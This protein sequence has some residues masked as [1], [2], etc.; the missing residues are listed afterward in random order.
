MN[1]RFKPISRYLT[2]FTSLVHTPLHPQWLVLRDRRTCQATVTRFARGTVLDIGC[3]NR[4]AETA[5]G[6]GARYIGLDYPATVRL[7]YKGPPDVFGDAQ[8]LPFRDGSIDTV[9][10]LDVLEH[11][12]D[13]ESALCEAARVLKPYGALILQ[14]PF[15]YPLHD[16]P[17]D[18]QRW[19]LYGLLDKVQGHGFEIVSYQHQGRPVETAA[20]LVAISM[21]KGMLDAVERRHPSIILAPLLSLLIL[22]VNLSGWLLSRFLP[23]SPFMP[24]GYRIIARRTS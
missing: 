3:G 5:L 22:L 17:F 20:A 19:T 6:P 1:E 11:L 2:W 13:S 15:L 18:F 4:W 14:V 23:E 24:L 21:A 10:L 9:L 8:Q 16:E 7:G 12:S